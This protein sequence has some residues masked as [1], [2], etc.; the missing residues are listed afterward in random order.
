MPEFSEQIP[1]EEKRKLLF[2]QLMTSFQQAA[3]TG[4]GKI[5]GPDGKIA[6]DLDAASAYIDLLDML[7]DLTKGNLEEELSRLLEKMVG[8]LKLNYL[9][10]SSK[11]GSTEDSTAA[12]AEQEDADTDTPPEETAAED[13]TESE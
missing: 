1:I 12:T 11:K 13:K 7:R 6:V 5:Q 2:V 10:E 9:E 8:D 4:L 3:W